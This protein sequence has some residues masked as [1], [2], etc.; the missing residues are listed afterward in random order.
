MSPVSSFEIKRKNIA[1]VL[2]LIYCK[3]IHINNKT[4][5]Y[6]GYAHIHCTD[7]HF[8]TSLS[9]CFKTADN[10]YLLVVVLV[11]N[12]IRLLF[13]LDKLFETRYIIPLIELWKNQNKPQNSRSISLDYNKFPLDYTNQ[14]QI[15]KQGCHRIS[16]R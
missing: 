8:N 15:L 13:I 14:N 6:Y 10:F 3:Q 9:P 16:S 1:F 5:L 12:I 11:K 4:Q 2:I 7:K